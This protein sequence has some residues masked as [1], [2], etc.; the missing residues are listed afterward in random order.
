MQTA[1]AQIVALTTWG[2]SCLRGDPQFN[3]DH[4]YPG[5][6]TF[7]FCEHVRFVDL[8]ATGSKWTEESYAADP[9]AWFLR[10]KQEG[11]TAL[12]MLYAPSD[13]VMLG[14]EK[15]ADRML[16]GFVGGGGRWIIEAVKP[17]VS[18]YWEG[19]WEVG[20]RNRSD[21]RIWRVTYGRIAADSPGY[22]GTVAGEDEVKSHLVGILD[23]ISAFARV[24]HLDNFAAVFDEGSALLA[25]S[26]PLQSVYHT[27]IAPPGRVSTTSAQLLAAAQTAWVFG[28]MGSWNDLGFDGADQVLYDEL[29]EELYRLLNTA[30]LV[31]ANSGIDS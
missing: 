8:K 5:N 18:D 16:A 9:S 4:F 10:M 2:N 13:G 31:A 28:G 21:R 15:V 29:S 17:D 12:R 19:R 24:H 22:G 20:D 30:I 14:N 27:D 11:I 1:L 7:G 3:A 25:S 6:S 26:E 23:R